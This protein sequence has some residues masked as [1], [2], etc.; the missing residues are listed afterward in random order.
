MTNIADCLQRG[1]DFGEI[2]RQIGIEIIRE[3]DQLVAR[4]SGGM[5]PLPLA[6]AR[7]RASADLK[8]A[9]KAKTA[10]LRHVRLNQLQA[11]SRIKQTI[12]KARDP[13]AALKSYLEFNPH[14]G[15][16]AESVR[17]LTEAYVTS[18]NGAL[19]D[20]LK[21][22]GPDVLSRS[23]NPKL[24][25][26]IIQELHEEASG[27]PLAKAYSEKV[28]GQQ[29]RMRRMANALGMD[30]GELADYG[31]PHT[32]DAGQLISKGF[33]SWAE[34]VLPRL[35]WHRIEDLSTGR[36]FVETAGQ[37][38]RLEDVSAFLRARYDAIVTGG[39]NTRDPSFSLG[40]R[41]LA[42]QRGEHRT[43][44]FDNGTAWMEYNR[45]FGTSEPFSAMMGGL[46]SLARDVAMLRVLGPNPRMGLNFAIQV[47][48]THPNVLKSPKLASKVEK[49]GT[50]A[51]VMLSHH[52]GTANV[53]NDVFWARFA[54]GVRSTLTGIQ[55]GAA[56][57]S[58]V[59]DVATIAAAAKTLGMSRANV[60]GRSVKLIFSQGTRE[61][62]ARAGYVAETLADGG[63]TMA[64]YMG[65][66][67]GTGL[68]ERL[69]SFTLRATGL[70]Y[71]TDMHKI[72]FQ[73][74][75]AGHLADMAAKTFAEIDPRIRMLFE[76]RGITAADWDLMRDPSTRF[77]PKAE[78]GGG[79][80]GPSMNGPDF[81]TPNHW[82]ETQTKVPRVE[83]EGLAMR[84]QMALQEQ[85]EFAIP[86]AS[87]E[88]KANLRDT[89]APGSIPGEILRSIT[90]YKNYP[91]SL[92][93]NQYRRFADAENWGMNRWSYA[94]FTFGLPMLLT[95]A[96]AVQNKELFWGRDPRPMDTPEFWLAALLQGGGIGIFGDFFSSAQSRTGGG[97]AETALGPTFQLADDIFKPLVGNSVAV[98]TG[99][100][101][102]FGR[103]AGNFVARYTPFF[104]SAFY[105]RVA[106]ARWLAEPFQ[107]FLDPQAEILRRRAM[108]KRFKEFG[109][110]SWW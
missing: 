72:A 109:N 93:L 39:W 35:A 99:E 16:S 3:Y 27:N 15:S 61:T 83:A 50:K 12:L 44:H 18:I 23:R 86:T 55:L 97:F 52:D 17:S 54:S 69:A 78:A 75:F 33:D 82:L 26:G 67:F 32:H 53:P 57:L 29:Q 14:A 40:G 95:G 46:H 34:Y 65:K 73:M 64:R 103:D 102:F 62:A 2:D 58:S 94:I 7:A 51:M 76:R 25:T 22:V 77:Y 1:I 98:M 47:A 60:L 21:E 41:S 59:T 71:L 43:L 38:P 49:A 10:R 79:N 85:V 101:S 37:K 56:V 24:L 11:M 74:E 84:W 36:M 92:T 100:K 19:A 81:M 68:P 89:A 87:L 106:Y 20:V 9:N 96:I 70:S 31:V 88:M 91:L 28:K 8:E 107:T 5:N 13:A 6:Q 4:Y 105:A 45:E 63:A 80:G 66:N 48:K 104:S 108:K 30:I 42:N 110:A 90:T